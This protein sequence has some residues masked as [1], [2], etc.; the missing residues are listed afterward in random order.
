MMSNRQFSTN[1]G[2]S[3]VAEYVLL[4]FCLVLS[5]DLVLSTHTSKTVLIM[6]NRILFAVAIGLFCQACFSNS[7]ANYPF[8][9]DTEKFGNGHRVVARNLGSAPVSVRVSL[10]NAQSISTDRPFPVYAV[11]PPGGGTLFLGE[12]HAA[13][14]GT[15]YSFN[16]QYSW[17]IGDIKANGSSN[18]MYRLPYSNGTTFQIGQAPGGPITTHNSP[19]SQFAVDIPMPEGTPILAARDGTVVLTEAS[20][21][22]GAQVPD[23]LDK[24][25]EIRIQHLDG[26]MAIYVHLAHGGVFVYPGQKVM[27]GQQIGL[28]GSTGYSSGPHLHFA[29]LALRKANDKFESVSL[30]FQFYVGNPPIAFSPQN[31]MIAKADYTE[32]GVLPGNERQ[33]AV[34]RE[35]NSAQR[36][37]QPAPG[38]TVTVD[39][40]ILGWADGL[41]AKIHRAGGYV[42]VGIVL[43]LVF[44]LAA[45]DRA[46]KTRRRRELDIRF[47]AWRNR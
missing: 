39:P 45:K 28:A 34:T 22:H 32:P 33:V 13:I 47:S 26:T 40:A 30:P 10:Q 7:A 21:I 23:M 38:I 3:T 25:N 4:S 19:D 29:I 9:V 41:F 36:E 6:W 24:A 18:A 17:A 2:L 27:A 46:E 5:I 37:D 42:W 11:V 12:I 31:G 44:V 8:T 16:T 43:V 35:D 15:G 20:Q 14:A 1:Y